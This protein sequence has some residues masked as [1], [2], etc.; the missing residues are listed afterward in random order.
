MSKMQTL[1]KAFKVS[2]KIKGVASMLISL[3]GFAAALLPVLIASRLRELTDELQN[4][5]GT[6]GSIAPALSIFVFIVVLFVAQA[7]F[8]WIKGYYNSLDR[9]KIQKYIGRSILKHKCEARYKYIEN[10]DDFIKKIR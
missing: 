1:F 2:I 3:L 7:V 4:L 5:M 8:N 10:H 9:M 6:R